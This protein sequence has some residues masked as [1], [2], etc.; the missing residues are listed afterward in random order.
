MQF[1]KVYA[2][3]GDSDD[4]IS[5]LR[6]AIHLQPATAVAAA[7]KAQIATLNAASRL[8]TANTLRRPLIHAALD[9]AAVVRPRL[10]IAPD[11]APNTEAN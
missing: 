3:T 10:T 9:Q 11:S 6:L 7:A 8:A 1:A 4:A 5:Y 2:A